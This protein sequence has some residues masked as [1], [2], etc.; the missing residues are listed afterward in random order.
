MF[1][2]KKVTDK[3]ECFVSPYESIGLESDSYGT[4]GRKYQALESVGDKLN[5]HMWHHDDIVLLADG[6]PESLYPFYVLKDR[7]E[8]N[9]LHLC[10]ISP[11]KFET[12]K[13]VQAHRLLLDDLSALNSIFYMD[14]NM[15]FNSLPD[16]AK[17][18]DLINKTVE[19]LGSM[20]PRLLVGIN[21]MEREQCFFDLKTMS[22]I[23]ACE[24]YGAID[25]NAPIEEISE[26]NFDSR[27]F[28]ATLG[29]L[30]GPPSYPEDSDDAREAIERNPVRV[31]GKRICNLLR[32]KRIQLA[33]A[34]GIIFD[35]AECPS[36]GACAG[37]CPKCD[38]ELRYLQQE[39][40]KIPEEKRVYPKFDVLEE[41]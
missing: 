35:S 10:V 11:F 24:G 30:V 14:S 20:L 39:I 28:Y 41:V 22:Y 38:E 1:G 8:H 33:E 16:Q 32:E 34:N 15:I 12:K 18:P 36:I 29:L 31:D 3:Y 40:E 9:R 13:K 17:F 7:N 27:P 6:N 26:I 2:R 25:E 19:E 21:D 37:T 5:R 4:E 23:P